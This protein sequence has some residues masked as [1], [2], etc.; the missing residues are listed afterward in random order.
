MYHDPLF[1]PVPEQ[2]SESRGFEREQSP[3]RDEATEP[4]SW[5]Q[6]SLDFSAVSSEATVPQDKVPSHSEGDGAYAQERSPGA[7]GLF[8]FPVSPER[9]RSAFHR[10]GN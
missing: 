7:Q 2:S 4:A 3:Q 6:G 9:R 1:M 10:E 8:G 5:R